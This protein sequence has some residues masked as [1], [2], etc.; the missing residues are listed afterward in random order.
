MTV[1]TVLLGVFL[2]ALTLW[3][4]G[5]NVALALLGVV[6]TLAVILL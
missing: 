3:R 4:L 1:P 6:C 5:L 2:A